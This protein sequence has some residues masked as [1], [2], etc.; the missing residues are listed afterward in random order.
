MTMAETAVLPKTETVTSK[1]GTSIAFERHGSGPVLVVVDGAMCYR[2]FGPSRPFAA[3]AHR[4]GAVKGAA[5]G[6]FTV[7]CYDRR[8][9][10]ASGNTMPYAPEREVEDLLAVIEATG[11]EYLIGFFVRCGSRL[12]DRC[13]GAHP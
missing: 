11:A 1:D 12:R 9:R 7:I 6:G 4:R 3:A 13:C 10:G 5:E 8:G 2:E